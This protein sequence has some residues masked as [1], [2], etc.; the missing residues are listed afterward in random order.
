MAKYRLYLH[1][2]T[3]A[4]K[5]AIDRDNR[6]FHKD[7]GRKWPQRRFDGK[8]YSR[9]AYNYIGKDEARSA[10]QFRRTHMEQDVRIVRI[11]G[12]GSP[13]RRHKRR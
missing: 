4:A 12:S 13:V 1:G 10:A 3:K 9:C 7:T 11:R 5:R 8:T 2:R 6:A